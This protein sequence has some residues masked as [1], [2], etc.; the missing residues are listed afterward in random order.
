MS[1]VHVLLLECR[2]S[3]NFWI[4]GTPSQLVDLV[5]VLDVVQME[6]QEE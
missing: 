6:G 5:V 2:L 4:R 1:T 3:N